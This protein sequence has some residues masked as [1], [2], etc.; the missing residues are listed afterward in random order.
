VPARASAYMRATLS[1][2]VTCIPT[3]L[4]C[5]QRGHGPDTLGTHHP[6]PIVPRWRR[7]CL[8]AHAQLSLPQAL[9]SPTLSTQWARGP[10]TLR[11]Q[12]HPAHCI[13]HAAHVVH[14]CTRAQCTP[15]CAFIRPRGGNTVAP[16]VL[17]V[18]GAKAPQRLRYSQQPR[19]PPSCAP[20]RCSS[21]ASR[22]AS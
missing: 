21:A 20:P 22:A 16:Q 4:Q 5:P 7:L 8:P 3:P 11:A 14:L 19:A 10:D 12:A 13:A 9:H 15:P 6:L 2:S 1:P 18:R 17:F